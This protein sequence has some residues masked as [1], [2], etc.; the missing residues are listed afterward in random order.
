VPPVL[1]PLG[2]HDGARMMQDKQVIIAA[3]RAHYV[4]GRILALTRATAV[5]RS[6]VGY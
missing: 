1:I 2:D 4:K 6:N 5:D 3:S